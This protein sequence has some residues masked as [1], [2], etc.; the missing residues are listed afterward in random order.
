MAD[1]EPVPYRIRI[2]V[3]GHRKLDNPEA[4]RATV[5]KALA[6]LVESL[7]SSQSQQKIKKIRAAGTTPIS[8]RLLTALAEGADRLVALEVLE[9]PEACLE[10]V[11]PLTVEDYLEDFSTEESKQEFGRLLERSR[12]PMRLRVRNVREERRDQADQAE[13]RREGYEKA[14][15]Y[16]VDHCDIL[17]AVWDGTPPR[18]R[19][20]TAEIVDYALAHSRRVIRVWGDAFEVLNRES[21]RD[22]DISAL[23]GTDRF[24]CL[25]IPPERRDA[26]TKKLYHD[27]FAKETAAVIPQ[28][29]RDI[30]DR[31]LLPYY[32]QASIVTKEN[33]R[34]YYRAGRNIYTL[35]AAA[36]GCAALAVL[37]EKIAVVG[38]SVELVLLIVMLLTVRQTERK[39][40]HQAWIENR[41]LAERIRC[42]IFM[43]ICNVE[44]L[45]IKVPA[46]MG[47]SQTTNDWTVRVFDEIWEWQP[48]LDGC[49][50]A[51]CGALNS[52]IREAWIR[53][54][55]H[56]NRNKQAREAKMRRRLEWAS[57]IVLPT[58]IAAAALH[59]VL[60]LWNP[61]PGD[62]LSVQLAH[63]WS[64]QSLAF[65]ALLFPAIAA[66][67]AGMEAHREHLR[68]EK[69]SANMGEQ[70]EKL[71]DQMKS[72]TTPSRF[73]ELLQ[74][75]DGE[76]MLRETQ[77]WL[78]LMRFVVIKGS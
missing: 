30:V 12:R 5:S 46:Y 33:Q 62:S 31:R 50:S 43:A 27:L 71:D 59:L 74:E 34:R 21:S 39:R 56:Y 10:A 64:H 1:F 54:Q 36:V 44:P 52:Y 6:A 40:T 47:H 3:T 65:V 38:F 51:V 32:A 58:T 8:Y 66:S 63:F 68:L 35:S 78:M 15:Q 67:L 76:V 28:T 49:S 41:Y 24:N 13:L 53:D 11:L 73:E 22:L 18:G 60:K 26:E 19:G 17:I 55:A 61:S 72:A 48:R 37:F 16:I 57:A 14:G 70:L 42:G 7:V 77:D 23:E 45:P 20:G 4:I 69:R 9:I 2:G 75:L 25:E 29:T